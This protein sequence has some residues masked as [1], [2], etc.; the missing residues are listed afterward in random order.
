MAQQIDK[1]MAALIGR[2]MSANGATVSY[3]EHEDHVEIV[4]TLK[5]DL[6]PQPP[7]TVKDGGLKIPAG[8]QGAVV[9]AILAVVH[10]LER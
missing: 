6:K 1:G 8:S 4:Y 9:N 10:W 5:L 3:V 2:W 7:I